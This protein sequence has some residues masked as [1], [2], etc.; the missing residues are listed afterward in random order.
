YAKEQLSD[1]SNWGRFVYLNS[2]GTITTP[3][4]AGLPESEQF[5]DIGYQAFRTGWGEEDRL[6]AFYSDNSNYGHNQQDD[7]SFIL[8]AG[9]EWLLTDPGYFNNTTAANRTMTTGTIGHNSMLVNG[10]GQTLKT[11]GGTVGF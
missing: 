1:S 11:G 7:N 6:L 10:A 9:G 5:A 2:S 3:E 8:N 4:A